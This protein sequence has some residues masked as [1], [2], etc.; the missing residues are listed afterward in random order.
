[1][2]FPI[3]R[4]LTNMLVCVFSIRRFGQN[5]VLKFSAPSGLTTVLLLQLQI[6]GIVEIDR[7]RYDLLLIIPLTR[8]TRLKVYGRF[9]WTVLGFLR[10]IVDTTNIICFSNDWHMHSWLSYCHIL[11][12]AQIIGA[13]L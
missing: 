13:E 9:E 4:D 2:I 1:M 3:L 12:F 7:A 11:L 5:H 8:G 6:L 10:G